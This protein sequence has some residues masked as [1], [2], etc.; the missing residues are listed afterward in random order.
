MGGTAKAVPLIRTERIFWGGAIGAMAAGS[1]AFMRDGVH[2]VT[3]RLF[4]VYLDYAQAAS[5]SEGES[6]Q[7]SRSRSSKRSSADSSW[8]SRAALGSCS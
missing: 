7:D 2:R 3:L 6:R 5:G 4:A 1:C 8:A